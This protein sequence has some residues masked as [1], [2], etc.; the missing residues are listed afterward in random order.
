MGVRKCSSIPCCCENP[1]PALPALPSSC[2]LLGEAGF[3]QGHLLFRL[4][5]KC[6]NRPERGVNFPGSFREAVGDFCWFQEKKPKPAKETKP[7]Q[8]SNKNKTPL[9][10]EESWVLQS[11]AAYWNRNP[12]VLG[13]HCHSF[14]TVNFAI[15]R[16]ASDPWYPNL[17]VLLTL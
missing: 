5:P 11:S 7:K 3:F 6:R 2:S 4:I 17:P 10:A 12:F 16:K 1:P 15:K 13:Y 8:I 9:S 14:S